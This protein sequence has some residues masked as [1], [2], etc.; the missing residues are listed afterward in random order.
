MKGTAKQKFLYILKI[1][2]LIVV[3][4]IFNLL[5]SFS[6]SKINFLLFMDTVFPVA[7]TFYAGLFPGL[8]IAFIHNPLNVVILSKIYGTPIFYYGFL[9]SIC[10]I[11]I[12]L[13]TWLFSRKKK[14]FSYSVFMTALY[15]FMIAFASAFASCICAALLDSFVKPLF[16]KYEFGFKDFADRFEILSEVFRSMNFGKFFSY[17]FPRIPVTIIDRIV[18]TFLGFGVYKTLLFMDKKFEKRKID[19]D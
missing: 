1:A 16:E 15:L 18:C 11:V 3:F 10:G 17:F 12:V 8:I 19:N 7:L 9:Y 5:L 6:T 14:Y 2:F 13:V 4:E